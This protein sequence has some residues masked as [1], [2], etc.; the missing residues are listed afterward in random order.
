MANAVTDSI[1]SFL[2]EH[3]IEPPRFD[4][5]MKY[6]PAMLIL[7]FF[8]FSFI[9]WIWEVGLHI[10]QAGEFVN[11]GVLFGPWLPIYGSGGVMIL[12]L[13]RRFF[14]R[15]VLTFFLNMF[16]CSAIEYF[17]SWFLETTKGIRW[18]D[19]SGY[20]LNINGRICLEGSVVFG[21]GGCAIIYF[22]APFL[23]NLYKR[24]KPF[25]KIL[26]CIILIS[27][28]SLDTAH[29]MIHPNTG[30]GITDDAKDQKRPPAK[31]KH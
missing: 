19:Y 6:G 22:L 10:A 24:I 4:Y 25:F 1:D 31:P 20:F 12:L 5:N 30:E 3:H 23:G 7:L 14:H 26:I 18:W 2:E 28:F 27:L 17:T 15:P 16:L 29:S 9:G 13:L 21:L 8:S 11:R